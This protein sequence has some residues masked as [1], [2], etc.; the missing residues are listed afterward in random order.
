MRS[1]A[2]E[3]AGHACSIALLDGE[4]IIAERHERI[5]RG[6]AERL[7]PWIA[8]LPDGGRAERIIVGCGPGSF[9]GVRIGIA[10]ARGLGLGWGV[11][12]SG[13]SSLALLAA[14]CPADEFIVAM[15]GG[16][17]ELL[18]QEYHQT[19]LRASG[20][21]V[22]LTPECAGA[23]MQADAVAGTG[24]ERLIAARGYGTYFAAQARA[25]NIRLLPP[26]CL[27]LSPSPLYGRAPDAKP[28][29]G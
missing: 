28:M 4:T 22:S 12:V 19:P 25:A 2:I 1:L 20:A 9:T 5:G 13:V 17:G 29:A 3:T 18:V 23:A 16:H 14:E 11:P 7:I 21:F 24:A 27:T 26:E 15:E 6:H 10:A 8:E